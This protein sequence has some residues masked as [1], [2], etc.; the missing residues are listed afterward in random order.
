MPTSGTKEGL[1]AASLLAPLLSKKPL[2]KLTWI[3]FSILRR[4]A[5]RCVSEFE[6]GIHHHFTFTGYFKKERL[7]RGGG[8]HLSHD[9]A[10]R[11]R[12]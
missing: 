1:V 5:D 6:G 8:V 7:G 4:T 9:A 11:Q 2:M 3:G 12:Y 10:D